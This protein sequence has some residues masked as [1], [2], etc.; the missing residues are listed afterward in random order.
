MA[1]IVGKVWIGYVSYNWM[2]FV[3]TQYFPKSSNIV[4]D[5]EEINYV[6]FS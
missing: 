5:C 4:L 2:I 3:R 6:Y 1:I